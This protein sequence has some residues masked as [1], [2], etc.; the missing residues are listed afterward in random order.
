MFVCRLTELSFLNFLLH[1][2]CG[3]D[4]SVP[5]HIPTLCSSVY[6]GMENFPFFLWN[7]VIDFVIYIYI[8]YVCKCPGGYDKEEKA[9]RAYDLAALKYWG[10]TA[11]TNFPVNI[12]Y[13]LFSINYILWYLLHSAL[14]SACI[15][16]MFFFLVFVYHFLILF[17]RFRIMP[18]N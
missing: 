4:F 2:I 15:S 10:P 18:R 5:V 8:F 1:K 12:T 11:T 9:A 17:L 14:V 13:S 3:A 6:L 16:T 7:Y